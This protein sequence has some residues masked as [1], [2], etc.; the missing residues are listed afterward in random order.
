MKRRFVVV[1]C[2]AMMSVVLAV[3]GK[4]VHPQ[5]QSPAPTAS[6]V[7]AQQAIINQYCATCHSERAKAAG[8]DSARKLTLDRLDL[9]FPKVDKAERSEFKQVRQ[10]LLEEAKVSAAKK[11]L[12]SSFIASSSI[13]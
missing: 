3:S 11:S 6:S 4:T 8:M 9:H 2:L 12:P 1:G 13:S 5:Q 7:S 10:A